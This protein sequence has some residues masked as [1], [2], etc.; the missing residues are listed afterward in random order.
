MDC[1]GGGASAGG[2]WGGVAGVVNVV[3]DGYLGGIRLGAQAWI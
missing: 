1:V 3:L 2:V